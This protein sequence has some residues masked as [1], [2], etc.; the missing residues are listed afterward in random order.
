M[1]AQEV[2]ILIQGTLAKKFHR[3]VLS[4][5]RCTCRR[6]SRRSCE[7]NVKGSKRFLLCSKNGYERT[8][9]MHRKSLPTRP[10][11][12]PRSSK[13]GSMAYSGNKNFICLH[14][15]KQSRREF[16]TLRPIHY[17]SLLS[18]I[19]K[20]KQF[21]CISVSAK[22]FFERIVRDNNLG[23]EEIQKFTFHSLR[24]NSYHCHPEI[25]LLSMVNDAD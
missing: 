3:L 18:F 25:I 16:E 23:D 17:Q 10:E 15:E 12:L 22:L 8:Q 1:E 13:H 19:C 24:R 5:H 7:R 14:E 6:Y 4:N 20:A 2:Q 11:Q 9:K 21:S